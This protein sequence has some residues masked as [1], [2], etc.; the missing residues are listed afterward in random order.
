MKKNNSILNFFI[1]FN[2]FSYQE[3]KTFFKNKKIQEL[4]NIKLSLTKEEDPLFP[5]HKIILICTS[6]LHLSFA[7]TQ[8]KSS[9]KN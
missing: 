3:I 1:F 2:L 9:F 7:L 8:K 5:L 6:A 4:F